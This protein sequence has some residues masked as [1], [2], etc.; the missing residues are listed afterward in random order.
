MKQDAAICSPCPY[1]KRGY[2]DGY[3]PSDARLM[4]IGEA[5]GVHES[6]T[7]HCPF[8]GDAGMELDRFLRGIH[9]SREDI[10]VTN[11]VKCNPP[12]NEDPKQEVINRCSHYL[13]QE[14]RMLNPEGDPCGP[15]VIITL[16]GIA[17]RAFIPEVSLEMVWGIP[18]QPLT[19]HWMIFPLYHPALGLHRTRML[20]FIEQ[21][22]QRLGRWLEG[23]EVWKPDN[24]PP[25]YVDINNSWA[26]SDIWRECAAI[27]VDTETTWDGNP[28][29]IQICSLQGLSRLVRCQNTILIAQVKEI[30][31]R[32]DLI[33]VMHDAMFD[34]DILHR[35]DIHP[36]N[37]VD[38]MVMA[39]LL[40]D[41]PMGLKPL[42]YHLCGMNM[43]EYEEVITGAGQDKAYAYLK[44][45]FNHA[46]PDPEPVLE[47]KA[48]G[49]P[50]IKQGQNIAKKVTRALKDADKG[51]G[52]DLRNRWRKMEGTEVVENVI[53]KMPAVDLRDV[54]EQEAITYACMD[55]DATLRVY[56]ILKKRIE[57]EGLQQVLDMD[58]RI[59]PMIQS[60]QHNGIRLDLKEMAKVNAMLT[61]KMQVEER[62][63]TKLLGYHIN[64]G[65][66]KQIAEMLDR[67]GINVRKRRGK[68]GQQSTS[69]E[70]LEPLRLEYPIIGH[71]LDWGGYETLRSTFTEVLPTK[72]GKDGKVHPTIKNTRTITG[73]LAMEDPNLQNIPV[74]NEEG[75]MIRNAFMADPGY[76][77]CSFDYRQIE[78]R[79]AAHCSQDPAM[80]KVFMDN[81]D[82]HSAT[83]ASMFHIPVSQVDEM[84]HRYPAK[85]VGFGVLYGISG[86]GLAIQMD[87]A[88]AKGWTA[89]TCNDLIAAWFNVYSGVDDWMEDNKVHAR[90]YGYV[91]DM[92]GRRRLVPEVHSTSRK[93]ME[94]GLRYAMNQPVQ[95]GAQGVIKKAM[96]DIWY[97]VL[98]YLEP[99]IV[100]PILQIHDDLLFN[101]KESE[102][103]WICPVIQGT[104]E[105]A[106]RLSIPTPVDPKGGERWGSMKKQI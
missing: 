46:W 25:N 35:L 28:L 84:K 95:S 19:G 104:M 99:G 106:V 67:E 36:P 62:E 24:I 48:G 81:V 50:H 83:A 80:L 66:P 53:G 88:G 85:R 38:T 4:F 3:G 43:R 9:I 26:L 56:P 52:V 30:L 32:L 82:I 94:E 21:G 16:G 11:L 13:K 103:G 44:G 6:F 1:Y 73:R 22:F 96:A 70:I 49:S 101:I 76:V 90:R 57:D 105:S 7:S 93:I 45:V 8:T 69:K 12:G 41:V 63:I 71:V 17:L 55:A 100:K 78:M 42:A 91:V 39:Y 92:F 64:P 79:M 61:N 31:E 27:A 72:I 54:P 47:I 37:V 29:Y 98:P 89:A 58:M 74:R 34:L 10:Y 2:V 75:H 65:S 23:E 87:M 5:P 51:T 40:Q 20:P 102:V 77:L 97:N 18:L 14:I 15:D 68:S 60:M 86:Q 33:T 59:I